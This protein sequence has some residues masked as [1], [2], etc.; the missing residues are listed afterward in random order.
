MV[1]VRSNRKDTRDIS[2]ARVICWVLNIVTARLTSAVL[3]SK[4]RDRLVLSSLLPILSGCNP[5]RQSRR[6]RFLPRPDP[7]WRRQSVEYG[8]LW[9]CDRRYIAP[10]R[11][12]I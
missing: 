10:L 11:A 4:R 5:A 8:L 2:P 1:A 6:T 9:L 7:A 12:A 3:A